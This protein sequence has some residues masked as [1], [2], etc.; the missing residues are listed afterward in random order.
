MSEQYIGTHT[1]PELVIGIGDEE[2]VFSP[3]GVNI[4]GAAGR[5]DLIGE[6]DE[7]T[8]V[9]EQGA[10]KLEDKWSIVEQRIPSPKLV[11]L[12]KESLL[13]ALRAVMRP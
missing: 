11:P 13:T 7:V 9:R 6:R 5:V 8:L 1:I 12:T 4:V 10:D 2:V 3:K